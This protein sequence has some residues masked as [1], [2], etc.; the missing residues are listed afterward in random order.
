MSE[1]RCPAR[2]PEKV[3]GAAGATQN[4][5]MDSEE[6]VR[7]KRSSG[8][9]CEADDCDRPLPPRSSPRRRFCSDA[10]RKRTARHVDDRSAYEEWRERSRGCADV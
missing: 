4:A 5:D 2:P 10:C 9:V 3:S 8:R 6:G 1:G 7:V